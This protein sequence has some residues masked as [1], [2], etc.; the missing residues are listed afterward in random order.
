MNEQAGVDLMSALGFYRTVLSFIALV[1]RKYYV[2]YNMLCAVSVSGSSQRTV[3]DYSNYY[4]IDYC[5]AP[6]LWDCFIQESNHVALGIHMRMPWLKRHLGLTTYMRHLCRLR[7]QIWMQFQLFTYTIK[8]MLDISKSK[9]K[10]K[11][12]PPTLTCCKWLSK[13]WVK[14]TWQNWMEVYASPQT[15]YT[16]KLAQNN[17]DKLALN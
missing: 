12:K 5:K 7:L 6:R 9:K 8:L 13:T 1:G 16:R 10:E 2:P 15:V 17:P 14:Q 3:T 11:C 4:Y